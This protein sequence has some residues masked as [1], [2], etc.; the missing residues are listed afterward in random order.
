MTVRPFQRTARIGDLGRVSRRERTVRLSL[1]RM[2]QSPDLEPAEFDRASH[3][4]AWGCGYAKVWRTHP[5][6]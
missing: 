6:E 5:E 2:A 3:D 4:D 1:A